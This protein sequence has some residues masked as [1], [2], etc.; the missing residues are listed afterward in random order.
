MEL[1]LDTH[2]FDLVFKLFNLDIICTSGQ[3]PF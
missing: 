3:N 2:A 1:L